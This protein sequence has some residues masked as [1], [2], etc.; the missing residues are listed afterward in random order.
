MNSL[1]HTAPYVGPPLIFMGRT[2]L[3][4]EANSTLSGLFLNPNLYRLQVARHFWACWAVQTVQQEKN[5]NAEK[6]HIITPI[7]SLCLR[8]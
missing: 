5:H 4:L 2:R 8:Y 6:C 1:P 7:E 3:A